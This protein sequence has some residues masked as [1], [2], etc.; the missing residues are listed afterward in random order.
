VAQIHPP[1]QI[2]KIKIMLQTFIKEK[3]KDKVDKAGKPYIEH[4]YRV[5]IPFLVEPKLYYI[6]F[7]HDIFED[8]DVTEKE[9]LSFE[10]IDDDSIKILK[11]LTREKDESYMQYIKKI[12]TD[13]IAI[14]I[15]MS[16]LKDN[17]DITRLDKI[18]DEDIARLKK[19]HKA[20]KFLQEKVAK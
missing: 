5:A 9:L 15:K 6:A 7:L 2:K 13:E 19:Y 4:L 1:F 3:F 17:M 10:E 16:D 18:K 14:K 12:A 20:Y 11:L 8:T